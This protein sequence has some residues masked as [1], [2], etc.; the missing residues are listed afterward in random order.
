MI[1]LS[2]EGKEKKLICISF[3]WRKE[4]EKNMKGK[5]LFKGKKRGKICEKGKYE[6]NM[7]SKMLIK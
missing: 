4:K 2:D 3:I 6:E 1:R 7:K 5:D